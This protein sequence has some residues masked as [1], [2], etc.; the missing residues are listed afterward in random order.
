[1]KLTSQEMLRRLGNGESIAKICDTTGTSR[2]EFD[3]WWKAECRRRVP[4][5]KGLRKLAGLSRP[6]RI[7]RDRTAFRTFTP[8]TN[9]TCSSASAMPSRRIVC[10]SST[11]CAAKRA[12]G[13]RK[14]SGPKR[15]SPTCCIAPSAWR[16]SP[17]KEWPTLPAD[18]RDLL[19]AY[20][21]GI[22]ALMEESRGCLPI[23]F[24]LLGYRPEPWRETDSL[25]IIGEFRWYL[26]GR[27][28]VI[29]I[30]ELVKRAVGDG[31]LYREFALGR[32]RRR[33]HPAS[34]RLRCEAAAT[35]REAQPAATPGQAATTGCS[36]AIAPTPASRSSPAI[37]TS[38]IT[39]SRSGTRCA[40]TAA[41]STSPAS[42]WPACRAS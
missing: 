16:R 26:T 6:V 28:P 14:S 3:S 32:G 30:P 41:A 13:S 39:P 33:E 29:A 9:A 40:C 37:R 4:V 34:G 31:P 27:F 38:R 8:T 42:R 18:V 11:T 25:A 7:E 12:A 22:N 10:F 1:M 35:R 17:S 36:P 24:D 5:A 21:A 19:A 23:E 20:T 15:S 2:N